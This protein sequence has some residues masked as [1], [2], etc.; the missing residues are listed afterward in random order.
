[1]EW[2]SLF[3]PVV[4]GV[5]VG[6]ALIAV[7][8]ALVGTF[9]VL[10]REALF[11]DVLAHAV[12]PGVGLAYVLSHRKDLPVLVVGALVVAL[13][14]AAAVDLLRREPRLREDARLGIVLSVSFGLGIVL[15]TA[16][17]RQYE[18]QQMG[19]W[20]FL[21]GQAAVVTWADVLLIAAIVALIIGFV[22]LAF[23][24]LVALSFDA[25][26]LRALPL[27]LRWVEMGYRGVLVCA[28]LVGVQSVGALL[29]VAFLVLP[30]MAARPWVRHVKSMVIGA[31]LVSLAAVL[32]GVWVSMTLP[33][34][35][36]GPV[37]VTAAA[38]V[39]VLSHLF[40]PRRGGLAQLWGRAA[41]ALQRWDEH[42]HKA[43][44]RIAEK[45]HSEPWNRRRLAEYRQQ[46]V[47]KGTVV[48]LLW[49]WLTGSIR[50]HPG[51]R[52]SITE[53]GLKKAVQVVRRHR[54]WELYL[55]R[56]LRVPPERVHTE[57]ELIEHVLSP[58]LEEQLEQMLQYPQHDPHG[59][60]IPPQWGK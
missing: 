60:P 26:F 12:L 47:S 46:G 5:L 27:P 38:V 16:L 53:H 37:I 7:G 4:M 21:F 10:R 6:N 31:V 9:A 30:P 22:A 45:E 39:V 55:E 18:P 36:T 51:F 40:A 58:E 57:A 29:M 50:W 41:R 20:R 1:M 34:V 33:R 19:L 25:Q 14:A 24:E 48:M 23:K 13:I 15:L 43:L 52:W 32:M 8:G 2:G 44:Y 3:H 56:F 49:L 54:L 35:A 11:G 17:Q 59:R 42:V 28:I